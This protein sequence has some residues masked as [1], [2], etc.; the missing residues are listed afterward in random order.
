MRVI[1]DQKG[2]TPPIVN[3]YTLGGGLD[4]AESRAQRA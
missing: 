2:V 1:L 4:L 3:Y